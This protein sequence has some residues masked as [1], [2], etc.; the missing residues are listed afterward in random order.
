MN[1]KYLNEYAIWNALNVYAHVLQ[2]MK[3]CNMNN[4]LK[5]KCGTHSWVALVISELL[6]CLYCVAGLTRQPVLTECFHVM[7]TK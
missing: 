6:F 2:L 4:L 7:P 1:A 3:S 5:M